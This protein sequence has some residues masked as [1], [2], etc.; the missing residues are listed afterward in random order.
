ML[1]SSWVKTLLLHPRRYI[2]HVLCMHLESYLF[3][4]K[5]WLNWGVEWLYCSTLCE[6]SV[7]EWELTDDCMAK[8]SNWNLTEIFFSGNKFFIPSLVHDIDLCS[9]RPIRYLSPYAAPHWHVLS[10]GVLSKV[11]CCWSHIRHVTWS[12]WCLV[13]YIPLLFV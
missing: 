8:P 2:Q 13:H 3:L 11:A 4:S 7:K 1:I 9:A 6:M 10:V 12:T 5:Y